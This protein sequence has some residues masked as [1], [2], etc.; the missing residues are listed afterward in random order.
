LAFWPSAALRRRGWRAFARA[1][2]LQQVLIGLPLVVTL[3]LIVNWGYQVIRKP[4]ELFFP[5]SG[6]LYKTP[7]RPGASTR[8]SLKIRHRRS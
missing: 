5:V 3:W 2:R 6:T 1:P 8:R 4:S 7:P